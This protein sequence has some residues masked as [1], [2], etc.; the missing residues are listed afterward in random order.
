MSHPKQADLA[1]LIDALVQGGVEFVVVGGAAAVLHGA[2]TS[3]QDLD[4]VHRR[5]DDNVDRLLAMLEAHDAGWRQGRGGRP[6]LTPAE[7]GR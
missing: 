7:P 6:G 1:A 2:P 5:T 3:T 4:L